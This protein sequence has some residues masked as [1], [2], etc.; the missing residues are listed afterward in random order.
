MNNHQKYPKF[1]ER[2]T[3]SNENPNNAKLFLC[4]KIGIQK[5]IKFGKSLKM[6]IFSSKMTVSVK[7]QLQRV[8]ISMI[9]PLYA[10]ESNIAIQKCVT[11]G[12]FMSILNLHKK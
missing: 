1:R 11:Y 2:R 8:K 10:F 9:S 4:H 3:C 12:F 5:Y 7:I 6:A